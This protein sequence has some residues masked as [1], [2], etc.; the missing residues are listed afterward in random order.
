[1][2]VVSP[3]LD[4]YGA[5]HSHSA[6]YVPDTVLS[7][8]IPHQESGMSNCRIQPLPLELGEQK[9]KVGLPEPRNSKEG[10]HTADTRIFTERGHH[11]GGGTTGLVL[12]PEK[13]VGHLVLGLRS[14]MQPPGLVLRGQA[15]V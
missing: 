2:L 14:G 12:S 10:P 8:K 5:L 1:M 15:G 3:A 11:E 4:K 9:R 13:D 6:Q 7:A